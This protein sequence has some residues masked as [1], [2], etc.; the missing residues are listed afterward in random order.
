[1]FDVCFYYGAVG[2]KDVYEGCGTSKGC[3][4]MPGGCVEIGQCFWL[5]TYAASGQSE[6]DVEIYGHAVNQ[7]TNH[8]T[9][10][11][12]SG[13]NHMVRNLAFF[14]SSKYALTLFDYYHNGGDGPQGDDCVAECVVYR[15]EVRV[16]L[17]RN[18][19][20][21][22]VRQPQVSPTPTNHVRLD[23]LTL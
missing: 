16:F 15:D 14:G 2:K 6:M 18:D 22:N 20:Y 23:A 4:G 11:G 21:R 12:F 17:S 10:L 3:Y 9:A 5:A 8:F 13:D 1:M 19:G 7:L